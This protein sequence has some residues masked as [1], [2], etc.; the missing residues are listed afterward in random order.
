MSSVSDT[1][2]YGASSSSSSMSS[3]P[4]NLATPPPRPSRRPANS[5]CVNCSIKKC[6]CEP[7]PGSTTCKNCFRHNYKCDFN[8]HSSIS[9]GNSKEHRKMA[10][11][12][13][14]SK[15]YQCVD[16]GTTITGQWRSG[17][18]GRNTLCNACGPVRRARGATN[19]KESEEKLRPSEKPLPLDRPRVSV[20]AQKTPTDLSLTKIPITRECYD[21]GTRNTVKWRRGA[22]GPGTLCNTCGGRWYREEK[23]KE[24]EQAN[25]RSPDEIVA[26][27]ETTRADHQHPSSARMDAEYPKPSS[28]FTAINAEENTEQQ[29]QQR[30]H[31]AATSPPADADLYGAS[32]MDSMFS[33][34]REGNCPQLTPMPSTRPPAQN[35]TP[36]P[37]PAPARESLPARKSAPRTS[38]PPPA[39]KL[40]RKPAARKST[41]SPVQKSTPQSVPSLEFVPKMPQKHM[42]ARKMA[43]PKILLSKESHEDGERRQ[44]ERTHR[45]GSAAN[46]S[47]ERSEERHNS[48]AG[49]KRP[50]DDSVDSSLYRPP[51][52]RPEKLRK[53][54]EA[55]LRES[56]LQRSKGNKPQDLPKESSTQEDPHAP[57][58][59]PAVPHGSDGA[60][61]HDQSCFQ[62]KE[63]QIN[64]RDKGLE[65]SSPLL[66]NSVLPTQESPVASSAT[67]ITHVQPPSLNKDLE[68]EHPRIV[69]FP[70]R[71]EI[72]TLPVEY[73]MTYYRLYKDRVHPWDCMYKDWMHDSSAVSKMLDHAVAFVACHIT[74]PDIEYASPVEHYNNVKRLFYENAEG[75]LTQVLRALMILH[76]WD[77]GSSTEGIYSAP[78]WNSI[79]ITLAVRCGFVKDEQWRSSSGLAQLQRH[80]WRRLLG[81][82]RLWA[83]LLN[84][85]PCQTDEQRLEEQSVQL[86]DEESLFRCVRERNPEPALKEW[87]RRISITTH[88]TPFAIGCYTRKQGQL[89]LAYLTF[90]VQQLVSR[91]GSQTAVVIACC[92]ISSLLKIFQIGGNLR[93]LDATASH[94]INMALQPLHA[95][96]K[97]QVLSDPAKAHIKDL[98]MA[99]DKLAVHSVMAQK[100]RD[101]G[102]LAK[103]IEQQPELPRLE[104]PS[105]EDLQFFPGLKSVDSKLIRRLLKF[106]NEVQP[107]LSKPSGS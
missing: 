65:Q 60:N 13:P 78:W 37:D 25:D 1:A 16:C 90:V 76:W 34:I 62:G 101:K 30:P 15:P 105:E 79:A 38:T 45:S 87:I 80:M 53:T 40:A 11:S 2:S 5:A 32:R 92:L 51:T 3:P 86:D 50:R 39:Q 73:K 21:C 31:P 106:E 103:D 95:A 18:E 81:R 52:P 99:V 43:P 96:A 24:I 48:D 107:H 49:Q 46:D 59:E 29:Q 41:P 67:K 10:D 19:M 44:Q 63:I 54:A 57:I 56:D 4:S 12:T 20:S 88:R 61:C 47:A 68:A 84:V 23:K 85:P 26:R 27:R 74:Q 36:S 71:I 9:K 64:P 17:P 33:T 7:Q 104:A 93:F 8:R 6:K 97:V 91:P 98:C 94:I 72:P 82:D 102:Y 70:G 66:Q 69:S 77:G 42:A 22:Y 75:N 55:A 35:D 83:F 89:C 100:I 58:T 14:V 28:G